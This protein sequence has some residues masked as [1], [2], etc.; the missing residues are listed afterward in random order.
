MTVRKVDVPKVPVT[1]APTQT[2][3]APAAQNTVKTPAP[4]ASST[5]DT[6]AARP[7]ELARA[8]RATAHVPLPSIAPGERPSAPGP[9]S[10]DSREGQ[11]ALQ[12]SFDFI[13]GRGTSGRGFA[14]P[15]AAET[16]APRSIE[17]D[18]LG[19]MHVRLDRTHEGVKVFG[20]QVIT[21]LDAEGKV[22][23]M[24]GET[25]PLN[26]GLGSDPTKLSEKQALAIA[27]KEFAG[28][29]DRA[30]T[31]ERVVF[32]DKNG[33]YKAAFRVELT[34]TTSADA[35][36]RM[37][38]MVD[39]NSGK[40]LDQWNQMGGIELDRAPANTN[41]EPVTVTASTSP[42]AAIADKST[43]TTTLD[44]ADDVSIEKLKLDLDIPHTYKGDLVVT[45]TSPS[46]KSAVVHN[47][48]GG[49]AD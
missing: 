17:R 31:V 4:A 11:A 49:S 9:V 33:E 28:K 36:K 43:T 38:Y 14:G 5:F 40:V 7:S 30:P 15:S 13:N 23:S 18:E 25:A 44:V 42:N 21:H 22:S 12:K 41:A 24:T 26:K 6:T 27:Q 16:F 3:K 48:T 19:M 34:N 10:V 35:P 39:A 32:Q 37:N 45:L 29:T 2:E 46:G 8:S 20:E 1:T 47:R